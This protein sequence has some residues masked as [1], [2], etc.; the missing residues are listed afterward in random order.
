MWIKYLSKTSYYEI[1]WEK[2]LIEKKSVEEKW[3]PISHLNVDMRIISKI[4][5]SNLKNVISTIANENLFAY[6]NNRLISESGRLISV[7]L[8][9]TN[10]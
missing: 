10:P 4:L 2:G 6:L 1:N 5:A 7:V 3:H 9:I 8:E